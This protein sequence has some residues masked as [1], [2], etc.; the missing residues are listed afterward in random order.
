MSPAQE[1]RLSEYCNGG[2]MKHPNSV[3]VG[4][5]RIQCVRCKHV[6]FAFAEKPGPERQSDITNLEA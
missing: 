2:K 5:N 6:Q 3:F 1:K 4:L